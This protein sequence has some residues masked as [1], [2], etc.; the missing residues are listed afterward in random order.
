MV[1]FAQL[2]MAETIGKGTTDLYIMNRHKQNM[3]SYVYI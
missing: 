1:P 3:G 2:K